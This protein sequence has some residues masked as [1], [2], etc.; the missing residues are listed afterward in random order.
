MPSMQN[1]KVNILN[2]KI[3][4]TWLG[5]LLTC[6]LLY[7]LVLLPQNHRLEALKNQVAEKQ[8]QYEINLQTSNPETRHKKLQKLVV[9]QDQLDEYV[10][11]QEAISNLTL[12][13]GR[14]A[15]QNHLELFASKEITGQPFQEIPN[16]KT[17]GNNYLEVSF[18]AGF[19]QFATFLNQLERHRP[20][21]M[22]D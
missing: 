4:L 12:G 18:K 9:A 14:L 5:L 2:K 17:I 1:I 15:A 7:A 6:G 13:I 21:I 19:T 16:C 10:T 20:V 11:V 3:G 22:L 8:R